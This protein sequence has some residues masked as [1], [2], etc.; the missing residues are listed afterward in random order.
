MTSES[1]TA[2]G[3]GD[4]VDSWGMRRAN[5]STSSGVTVVTCSIEGDPA[6]TE[7]DY[8]ADARARATTRL[9]AIAGGLDPGR[10]SR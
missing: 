1:D 2:S 4:D 6:T 7:P 8:S 9:R 10:T 3:G 5:A